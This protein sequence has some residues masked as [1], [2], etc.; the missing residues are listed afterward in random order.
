MIGK[1]LI[2]KIKVCIKMNYFNGFFYSVEKDQNSFG[3]LWLKSSGILYP[4]I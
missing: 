3:K 4:D 1:I 2:L